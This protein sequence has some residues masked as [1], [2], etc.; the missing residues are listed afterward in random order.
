MKPIKVFLFVAISII[1]NP[2]LS[3]A[4]AEG[5]TGQEFDASK[6]QFDSPYFTRKLTDRSYLITTQ[7]YTILFYVGDKG[8]FVLDP[9]GPAE[10]PFVLK[11]ISE[12]TKLPITAVMY[13]HS[14]RDHIVNTRSI[15]ATAEKADIKL[16]IIATDKTAADLKRFTKLGIPDPTEVLATPFDTFM[17]EDL[18]VEVDT[19]ED[20]MHSPDTSFIYMPSEK[21]VSL[22]DVVTPAEL[23]LPGLAEPKDVRAFQAGMKK[24][25]A[26]DWE[27]LNGGHF[28]LGSKDT[29]AGFLTYADDVVSAT[30]Q[31]F[32]IAGAKTEYC[33]PKAPIMT[34]LVGWSQAVVTEATKILQPKYGHL[35][36]F[37]YLVGSHVEKAMM[38]RLYHA[39]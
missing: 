6:I 19:P 2:F 39:E 24:L 34:C 26:M 23:P 32:T 8:V 12:V 10:L 36:S 5:D 4:N 33:I 21:I 17:F 3:S 1:A 30:E 29:V 25:L 27:Y 38:Q 7:L 16:R 20:Y 9:G 31:A 15:L 22:V 11:A 28:N 14:H 35:E 18:K 13:S 37:P